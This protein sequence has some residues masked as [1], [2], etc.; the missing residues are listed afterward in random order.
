MDE[1]QMQIDGDGQGQTNIEL[2]TY[3]QNYKGNILIQRLRFIGTHSD[4]HRV[5]A[6]RLGLQALKK[7]LNVEAYL[8]FHEQLVNLVGKDAAGPKDESWINQTRQNAITTT[9]RLDAD[10]RNFKGN[11][12]KET[13]KRGLEE[14]AEHKLQ[15][16]DIQGALKYFSKSRDYCL[17]AHHERSMCL[18]IIKTAILLRQWDHVISYVKKGESDKNKDGT[19]DLSR[20][21]FQCAHALADLVNHNYNNA[22]QKFLS[23][24]FESFDYSEVI[25]SSNVA[26]YGGLCSLASLDRKQL[27]EKVLQSPNFKQFLELE[28]CM[29]EVIVAYH[30]FRF[31]DA[32][33]LLEQMKSGLLLDI[34]L[35]DHVDTLYTKIRNKFLQQYLKPFEKADLNTMAQAFGVSRAE[36]EED[37]ASLVSENFIPVR[38]DT[39]TGLAIVKEKNQRL[40][41]IQSAAVAQ[42]IFIWKGYSILMR[43]ALQASGLA[44]GNGGRS[45]PNVAQAAEQFEENIFA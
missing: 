35:V 28:P 43:Q 30:E 25:S 5:D 12:V 1:N 4:Y 29:R 9:E 42:E 38:I 7:S 11:S 40:E 27:K 34:F 33:Q 8:E 41:A 39:R 6:L 24:K 2:D 10:I 23:L 26:T 16:G 20:S 17:Q 31:L 13:I 45:I 19:D 15:I 21:K 14:M 32:L 37:L 3:L 36:L 18:N 44:V 22:A